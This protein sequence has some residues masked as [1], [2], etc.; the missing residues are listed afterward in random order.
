[1]VEKKKTAAC[2]RNNFFRDFNEKK[3]MMDSLSRKQQK[4]MKGKYEIVQ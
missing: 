4:N 1:M 3:N 2:I